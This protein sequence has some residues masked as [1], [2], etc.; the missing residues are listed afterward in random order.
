MRR[1]LGVLGGMLFDKCG[2][3]VTGTVATILVCLGYFLFWRGIGHSDIPNVRAQLTCVS[4]LAQSSTAIA[5]YALI[6]GQGS[7]LMYTVALN[8]NVGQLR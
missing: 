2:P 5:L 1:W 3:R 4:S 6:M 7:S 8:T